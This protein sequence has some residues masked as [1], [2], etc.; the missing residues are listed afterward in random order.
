MA[1]ITRK[2]GKLQIR[3]QFDPDSLNDEQRTVDVV[4]ATSRS[5]KM[6]DWE[7]GRFNEIL[8]FDAGHIRLDR[9][10]A[11]APVLDNHNR[12]EGAKGVVGV[13]DR[14]W[15]EGGQG[16]ATL[17]FSKREDADKIYQDVKD[18]ILRGIS[19]GY[20]VF[21]YQ[22]LTKPGE[23]E[24]TLKAVDWEPY[25][26]SIAPIPAD[27]DASVRS[28]G[29]NMNDVSIYLTNK[30]SIMTIEQMRAEIARLNGLQ[31]RSADEDDNLRSLETRLA[32]AERAA[33]PKPATAPAHQPAPAPAG[34]TSE[35]VSRAAQAAVA[36]E[37][38]RTAD[39]L[40]AVRKA[41]L[42]EDF[43][44]TLIENG[45]S[46]D[47]ARAAI[48]DKWA[49]GQPNTRSQHNAS[50]GTEQAEK[51]A[52]A[53]GAAVEL[54]A[55]PSAE[56]TMPKETVAAAREFRGMSLLRMA[57]FALEQ[58]GVNTRGMSDVQIAKE[59]M[60]VGQRS[61]IGH[62][63]AD[64]PVIL[65]TTVNRVLRQ[66]YEYAPR[67]FKSFTKQVNAKDFRPMYRTQLS[68]LVKSFD[69]IAEGGEYKYNTVGETSENY[70]IAKYGSLIA[71]TWEAI[72]NDDLDAFSRIPA[73]IAQ[74]AAQK[75]S[76]I[77]WGIIT[78]NP[79][80]ADGTALFHADHANLA[81]SGADI[82]IASLSAGR[83]AIRTQKGPEGDYLNLAPSYLI[84]GPAKEQV[85]N[86]FTS[87]NYVATKNVDINPEYNR[88]LE[89]IVE[90]RLTG[91]QWYLSAT[92]GMIDTI[93][94]AFLEGEGEL[95]TEQRLGF[96]VDG[97]EIKAR[98]CFGAK[99][100]DWRGMY[101][102]PGA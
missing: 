47:Q 51:V 21:K 25:E 48:I 95:Y 75:Q 63:I 31:T 59:A 78:G 3:A 86:Q 18:G 92:P 26:I 6:R 58:N 19:V 46:V 84:V 67:T 42:G 98:M 29:E 43:A 85:A 20:N 55:N 54:R 14:A 36:A 76:D 30:S 56:R 7:I 101:K 35:D 4:F 91:N 100:I 24:R 79:N 34:V 71:I 1:T 15:V 62:S 96:E 37:R 17:R 57:Q 90:P 87:A 8:S 72:K 49:E 64:F 74:K 28:E 22:D 50:V 12:Y 44:R 80:M 70:K 11:G 81:A 65:G 2:I 23:E 83:T 53:M 32:E 94:Y 41:G 5:V 66:A 89:V 93:E 88:T 33:Q 73:A 52:D 27:Y 97:L 40:A 68:G 38:Q 69:Q 102:N 13:V 99:A 9:L 60:G 61:G 45:S 16:R 39:I 82:S 10:N 77:V